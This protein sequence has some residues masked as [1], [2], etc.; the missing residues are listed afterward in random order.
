MPPLNAL[1]W[2]ISPLALWAGVAAAGLFPANLLV[3]PLEVWRSFADLLA[4]G[5][6]Q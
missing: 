2:L 6:L 3:P 5:E 4:T 1:S